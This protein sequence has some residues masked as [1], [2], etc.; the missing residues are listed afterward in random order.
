MPALPDQLV[1]VVKFAA[2]VGAGI[3][4]GI[5]V[6]LGW[7]KGGG[8]SRPIEGTVVSATLAD[9][10]AVHKL[11]DVMEANTEEI[12]DARLQ[13]HRDSMCEVEA[14]EKLTSQVGVMNDT[15]RKIPL[16]VP[17]DWMGLLDRM[18]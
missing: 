17:S 12:R 7:R 8:T 16:A 14:T 13:R 5:A 2:I 6:M 18:K 15:L 4:G 10:K 9:G 3:G 11:I 1:E